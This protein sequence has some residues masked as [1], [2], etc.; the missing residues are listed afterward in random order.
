MV[1]LGIEPYDQPIV[2]DLLGNKPLDMRCHDAHYLVRFPLAALCFR[3][4]SAA[5]SSRVQPPLA[6]LSVGSKNVTSFLEAFHM[7]PP[8]VPLTHP[9]LAL[10]QGA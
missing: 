2:V 9:A 3:H 5:L 1:S 7:H 10:K 8:L 6:V 4:R